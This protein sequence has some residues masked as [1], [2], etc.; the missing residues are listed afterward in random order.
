MK[1]VITLIVV[2]F[3]LDKWLFTQEIKNEREEEIFQNMQG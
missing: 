2:S 1:L 3:S